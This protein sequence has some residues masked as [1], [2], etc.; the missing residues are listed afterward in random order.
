M[1]EAPSRPLAG[2]RVVVTRAASAGERLGSLLQAAGAD[3]IEVPTIVHTDPADGG[4][5]L[6]RATGRLSSFAWVAFTSATAVERVMGTVRDARAF[7][8]VQV[9]AVGGATGAALRAAGIEPDLI[10]ETMT[11]TGLV[12]AFP[13]PT[14]R[15]S[16]SRTA[17]AV[18]LPQSAIAESTVAEGLRARGW[19]VEVVEAYGTESV[20]IPEERREQL[21]A[22]DAVCFTSGSTVRGWVDA[23]GVAGTPAAVVTI[24]PSTTSAARDAGL[25]V[26]AEAADSTL[27]ELVGA[28]VRAL[29]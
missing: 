24:G 5:A 13:D 3:V 19:L 25:S 8:G 23:V 26:T 4:A 14:D 17:D 28:V 16:G 29:T 1:T 15:R 18:L 21:G 9:A 2:R 10:P 20:A 12:M 11:G 22:A 7:G 6:V 27:E